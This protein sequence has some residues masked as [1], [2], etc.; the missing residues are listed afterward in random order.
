MEALLRYLRQTYQPLSILVYGSYA[1]GT[2]G[3]ASDFDALVITREGRELHDTSVVD[4][5]RLD[6]FVYPERCFQ[7]EYDCENFFQIFDG[8]LP[9]DPLG[10]GKQLQDRVLEAIASRPRKTREDIRSDLDWCE[11]ML[12]RTGRGDGEGY[13]RWH[14]LLTESL[15]IFCDVVDQ[16]YFG[17]KKTLNWMR[18]AHPEAFRLYLQALESFTRESLLNWIHYLTALEIA[19]P[20]PSATSSPIMIPNPSAYSP[21]PQPP[22]A[23]SAASGSSSFPQT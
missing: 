16:C 21:M 20:W 2:N 10:L 9:E 15:E 23:S 18:D 3:P 5:I 8:I 13:F 19:V 6:V 14:W 17:P 4:G 12:E 22:A 1:N 7:G 11:K